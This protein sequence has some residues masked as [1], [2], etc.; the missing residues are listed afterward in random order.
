M[1]G[2]KKVTSTLDLFKYDILSITSISSYARYVFNYNVADICLQ[3][4]ACSLRSVYCPF[5]NERGHRVTYIETYDALPCYLMTSRVRVLRNAGS[6]CLFVPI[7]FAGDGFHARGISTQVAERTQSRDRSN[8]S[9]T[10][11]IC[12]IAD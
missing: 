2:C 10:R 5:R 7:G 11:A 3:I 6:R 9:P 8:Y 12:A 4:V 1:R